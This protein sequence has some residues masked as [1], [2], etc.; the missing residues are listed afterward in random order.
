MLCRPALGGLFLEKRTAGRKL[1]FGLF[2]G[3]FLPGG[4]SP[5]GELDEL[6]RNLLFF[7]LGGAGRLRSGVLALC[8]FNAQF[9]GA[10]H[11]LGR[12]G[13][14]LVHFGPKLERDLLERIVPALD[15]EL[16]EVG[17]DFGRAHSSF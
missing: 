6:L 16:F 11:C 12:A 5:A 15:A 14:L 3:F 9:G 1:F 10:H 17:A 7:V 2:F 8:V 13:G 4:F